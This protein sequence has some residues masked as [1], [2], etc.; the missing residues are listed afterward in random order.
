MVGQGMMHRFQDLKT[1]SKLLV[2]F[3]L[4]S[5]IIMIMATAGIA[6]LRQLSSHSQTVYLD[7]TVPLAQFS[8][9]GTALTR[10][11]QILL[12]AVV[13]VPLDTLPLGVLGTGEPGAGGGHLGGLPADDLEPVGQ[14]RGQ[15]QVPHRRGGLSG[16]V[17]EEDLEAKV[18]MYL[19]RQ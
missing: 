8:E 13:Q 18:K 15:V 4:V 14:F 17:A 6:T 1:Q 12:D 2:S 5:V 11:H 10:H 16:E 9:L 3:G 7:Y 19:A